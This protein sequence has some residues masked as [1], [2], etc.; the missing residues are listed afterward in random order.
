M[1]SLMAVSVAG[2]SANSAKNGNKESAGVSEATESQSLETQKEEK[3]EYN[4][5][6]T[7]EDMVAQLKEIDTYQEAYQLLA[8][9]YMEKYESCEVF[10]S[11]NY[12]D[13]DDNPEF[14]VMVNSEAAIFTYGTKQVSIVS[15]NMNI[16]S[17]KVYDYRYIEKE[18]VIYNYG[19]PCAG[20]YYVQ[21]FSKI[22]K[23]HKLK[24]EYS[25]Q[26]LY[27][28]GSED[29]LHG[30]EKYTGG[31]KWTYHK[32]TRKGKKV[33]TVNISEED[34]SRD[35]KWGKVGESFQQNLM[36]YDRLVEELK[37]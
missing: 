18:N 13:E 35:G 30:T 23:N 3:K 28:D 27:G 10:F 14:F 1:T 25:L 15:K 12:V 33:S 36:E 7:L 31:D 32:V 2:C 16:N 19:M 17:D 4:F 5:G 6:G 34:Y 11:L 24:F 26:Q 21:D 9:Y 29:A 8:D 20:T 22:D 37:K